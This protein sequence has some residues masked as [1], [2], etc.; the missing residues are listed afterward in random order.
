MNSYD[1]KSISSVP[2]ITYSKRPTRRAVEKHG[3][4]WL[5]IADWVHRS[6]ADCSDRYRQH[7]QYKGTKRKGVFPRQA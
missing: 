1:G 2:A 3:S 6:P 5:A 7:V 4:D